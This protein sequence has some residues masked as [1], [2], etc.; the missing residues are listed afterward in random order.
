MLDKQA[1]RFQIELAMAALALGS[2]AL[3]YFLARG[4]TTR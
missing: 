3:A 2:G 1:R 4:P